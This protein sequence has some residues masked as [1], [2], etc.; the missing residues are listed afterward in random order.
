MC[1][2]SSS[3]LVAVG[4]DASTQVLRVQFKSGT[5][6]YFNVP[7]SIYNGLMSAPSKGQ[8]HAAYIKNAY[9]YSRLG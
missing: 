2:V 6:D 8:Y 5:Y 4:Y 7:E 9:R 1:P 3:N